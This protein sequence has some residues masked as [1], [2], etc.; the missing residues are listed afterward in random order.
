MKRKMNGIV[1]S[2]S[3]AGSSMWRKSSAS[4]KVSARRKQDIARTPR[5]MPVFSFPH[6]IASSIRALSDVSCLV[7]RMPSRRSH[8]A[9]AADMPMSARESA[10]RNSAIT[11]LLEGSE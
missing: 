2:N 7:F 10:C 11:A 5:M 4:S 8:A 3:P 1:Y 6:C 9:R